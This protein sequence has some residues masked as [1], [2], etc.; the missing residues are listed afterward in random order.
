MHQL[1]PAVTRLEQ[2][3]VKPA[4][5]LVDGGYINEATL[6]A[7]EQRQVEVIGPELDLERRAVLNRRQALKQAGIAPEFGADAFRILQQGS[8]LECPAGQRL[9]RI[10]DGAH[11]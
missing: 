6:E 11:D 1:A 5:V 2:A 9:R 4:R 7:M 10:S 8:A 3:G